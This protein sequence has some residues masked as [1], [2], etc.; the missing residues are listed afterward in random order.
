MNVYYK[1]IK[2]PKEE[3]AYWDHLLDMD[4]VDYGKEGFGSC[5]C[6]LVKTAMFDDGRFADVK[7]CTSDWNEDVWSEMVVFNQD[8]GQVWV[9][10]V[11][12]G[13]SGLWE[14]EIDGVKYLVEV[15]EE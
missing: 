11:S 8:G 2:M 7:V 4:K 13:L 10:D 9:S 3:L 15:E 1:K 14:A 6:V 12:D 5:Q